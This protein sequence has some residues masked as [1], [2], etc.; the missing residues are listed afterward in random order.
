MAKKQLDTIIVHKSGIISGI[1]RYT[2]VP[3]K[4][5]ELSENNMIF[6]ESAEQR[7]FSATRSDRGKK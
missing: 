4:A 5:L 2:E 6:P 1:G 3:F 7:E